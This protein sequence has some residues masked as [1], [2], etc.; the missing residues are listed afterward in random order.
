MQPPFMG[1]DLRKKGRISPHCGMNLL[2]VAVNSFGERERER[3]RERDRQTDR[4]TDRKRKKKCNGG[5][6]LDEAHV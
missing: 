2:N 5:T 1:G 6:S 3:E 4:Q